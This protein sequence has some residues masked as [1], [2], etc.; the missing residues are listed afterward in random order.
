MPVLLGANL[1]S[2]K[3][4]EAPTQ[5]VYHM[6][7]LGSMVRVVAV[8]AVVVAAIFADIVA[9]DDEELT[10]VYNADLEHNAEYPFCN[11]GSCDCH[12]DADAIAQTNEWVEDG[13]MSVEDANRHFHGQTI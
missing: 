7:K 9:S 2:G 12:E 8:V 10:G 3:L 6:L 13:L 4:R 5:G 1:L 11:D